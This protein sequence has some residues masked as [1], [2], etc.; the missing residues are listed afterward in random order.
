MG[1]EIF[2]S[3]LNNLRE[4][5]H[6]YGTFNDSNAKLDEVVK[7]LSMQIYQLKTKDL[8]PNSFGDLLEKYENDSSFDLRKKANEL[9][10]YIADKDF[11]RDH[12]GNSIFGKNPELEVD[13]I[14]NEILYRVMKSVMNIVNAATESNSYDFDLINEVFGH[15]VRDNFRGNIED[16]QYMTPAEVVDY[17]AEIALDEIKR[18]GVKKELKICDPCCGVGSFLS[19][20]YRKLSLDKEAEKSKVTIVGQDKVER[21]ARL[22]M[23]NLALFDSNENFVSFGNSLIGDSELCEHDNSVD[24]ILTN[25]PF[26]AKF[27]SE[28]LQ[29][30]KLKYPLLSTLFN[31]QKGTFSSEVLFIDR[32]LSLLNDDGFLLAVVPDNVISASGV[33]SALR[34]KIIKDGDISVRGIIE[35][36]AVTFAQAGTRTK[37]SILFIEKKRSF[38]KG[39]YVG[40]CESL[41]FEVSVR[42]GVTNKYEEGVNE[43]PD[44]LKGYRKI[45]GAKLGKNSTTILTESPSSVLVDEKVLNMESWTPSHFHVR[46]FKAIEKMKGK[47]DVK[48][49]KL[50]E[51]ASFESKIRGKSKNGSE[52]K[53]ISVLHVY[54]EDMLAIEEVFNYNPKYPG[55][56][57]EAGDLLFSKINPRI[58]RMIIVPELNVPLTC[59]SEF[60]VLKAKKGLTNEELKVLLSLPMVQEQI[61]NLTSGTSS[62]HNRIKSKDLAN[63]V[64]PVPD[65]KSSN[66]KEFKDLIAKLDKNYRQ[67]MEL[68]LKTFEAKKKISESF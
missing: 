47:K 57:C 56:N 53:C 18:K 37:T 45:A 10:R 32:C 8:K 9:F 59:S 20:L 7:I 28:E 48:L 67:M 30:E 50:S 17:M 6:K 55:L 36:P 23:I 54:N 19:V 58:P 34:Q 22:T 66:G 62:S 2:N 33:S 49:K 11:Y 4:L 63:V 14:D 24:V 43:L 35:L 29:S 46:R 40:I 21:M 64:I 41:G 61:V 52:S 12:S 25:P 39:A 38:E 16:A 60:E 1:I 65:E 27:S 15:F 51:V 3:E 26:G 42:K 44:L 13:K 5:F 31:S 68:N